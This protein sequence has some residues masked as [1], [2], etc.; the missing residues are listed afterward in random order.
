MGI[1]VELLSQIG[2]QHVAQFP[3]SHGFGQF[4]ANAEHGV[5]Q[6]TIDLDRR[7]GMRGDNSLRENVQPTSPL[8]KHELSTN[9]LV[10]NLFNVCPGRLAVEKPLTGFLES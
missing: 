10:E 9:F 3:P 5:P 2:S 1:V 7:T 4:D 8:K 6:F